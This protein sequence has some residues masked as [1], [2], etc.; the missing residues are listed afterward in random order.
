MRNNNISHQHFHLLSDSCSYLNFNPIKLI[1]FIPQSE[2]SNVIPVTK[3]YTQTLRTMF[4]AMALLM[5]EQRS[6]SLSGRHT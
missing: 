3:G 2:Q 5:V 6:G 1:L 4:T